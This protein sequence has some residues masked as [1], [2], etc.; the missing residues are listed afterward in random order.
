MEHIQLD[1]SVREAEWL[2]EESKW[3]IQVQ[4]G[5]DGPIVE[6]TCDIFINAGG[7]LK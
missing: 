1:C 6:D 3:K 4:K 2:E 7:V 5:P